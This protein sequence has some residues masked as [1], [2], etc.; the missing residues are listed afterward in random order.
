MAKMTKRQKVLARHALGL[1]N[2]HRKSYRNCF[3]VAEGAS[4]HKE[5]HGLAVDGLARRFHRHLGGLCDLFV[6]TPEGARL[7]LKQGERLDPED[8]PSA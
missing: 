6:L 4:G 5:W 2:S 3:L 7:A 8:F 1:P